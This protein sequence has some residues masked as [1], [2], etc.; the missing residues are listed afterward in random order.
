[1]DIS[2]LKEIYEEYDR[3]CQRAVEAAPLCGGLLGMGDSPKNAPC[4]EIFYEKAGAWTAAFV[5]SQPTAREAAQA[6]ALILQAAAERRGK[7]TYW[8]CYAAQGHGEALV[9]LVTPEA[10]QALSGWYE[11]AYPAID[12]MPVQKKIAKHLKKQANISGGLF[13]LG[14]R[15]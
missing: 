8:Y 14:R 7:E 1:M 3:A 4:H 15:P 5:K 12:R 6:L 11:A 2:G 9:A 13:G 10:A